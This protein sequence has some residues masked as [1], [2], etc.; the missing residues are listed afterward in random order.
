MIFNKDDRIKQQLFRLPLLKPQEHKSETHPHV[1]RAFKMQERRH[2]LPASH[3]D[4]RMVLWLIWS[5]AKIILFD[6]L[7]NHRQDDF[8]KTTIWLFLN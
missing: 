5:D 1:A 6:L 7:I 8:D 2:F 4:Y 3:E